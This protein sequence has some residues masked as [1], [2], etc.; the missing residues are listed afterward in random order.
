MKC[1]G[2]V[3]AARSSY[4]RS[5]IEKRILCDEELKIVINEQLFPRTYA[6][7]ILNAIYTDRLDLNKVSMFNIK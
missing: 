6:R 2:I 4:L 3:L 1:S 7:I 5:L